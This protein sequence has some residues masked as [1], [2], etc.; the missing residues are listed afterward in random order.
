MMF[1]LSLYLVNWFIIVVIILFILVGLGFMLSYI[2]TVLIVLNMLMIMHFLGL[3]ML[4]MMWFPVRLIR[5]MLCI[6]SVYINF[7]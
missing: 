4:F 2:L 1:I 3:V 5:R 7:S 6:T